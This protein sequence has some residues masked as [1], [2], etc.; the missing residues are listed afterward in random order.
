MTNHWNDL[1]YA[2]V[3][4]VIG[5]NPAENHPISF[6][7]ITKAKEKGAKLISVDPRY[8]RTSQM[9]DMYGQLRSGTDIAFIGGIINYTLENEL[10][11][12]EYVANYT[13]AAN[14]VAD[15]FS[16]DDGMFNGYDE[17]KRSYDKTKWSFKTDEAGKTMKDMTMKDPNCVLQLMKK[18]YSRY[19]IDTV[20]G[21][22]G[23]D[24]K[25]YLEICKTY[26][27]T[28]EIG[29]AGTI[30][31]AMGAT[32]HT[33]GTQ[34][35]RSY[36]ILQMLLGNIG[37]QG[38]GVNALRGESNVQGST[39]FGLLYDNVP[40]Y[41]GV[42]KAIEG[43]KTYEGFLGRITPK[44]G[45][46]VNFP[47]FYTSMLKSF[48]GDHATKEN[49]FGYQ[50]LP[51]ISGEKNYSFLR[52]FDAMYRKEL[53]GLLMFGT[54][55]VVGGANSS[56]S[57]ESLANLK[58]LVAI[59]LWETESSAF[60]QKEAGSDPASIQTEVIFLPACSSFEKEGS[61][62]NSGRWM[63]YRWQAIEPKGESKADLEIVH[64]LALKLKEL[65]KNSSNPADAPMQ[66]LTWDYG[67]G[68]HPDIDLVCREING[69]D[70]ATKQQVTGFGNLKDDGSTCC[71][72]WIY[73]GFYPGNENLAKRR[74]NKDT[75]NSNFLNW[76]FAWPANRRIL[77]NRA[78]ADLNGKAWSKDRVGVEWDPVQKKWVGNDVP[79]FVATK[80]PDDP[81]FNDPFI[82]QT[83]G[84]GAIFSSG[85]NEGPFPEHYE[86]YENPVNNSFSKVQLNPAVQFGEEKLS[87]KGDVK[88]Y[89]IVATTYRVSEHWQ[90]GAMTRNLPWLAE[91]VPHMYVE[92]S[93]ELAKEK[94][95][96]NGDKVIVSSVRD[97]IEVYAMVTKRFKPYK[98]KDKT[99]HHIGMPWHFGYKGIATGATANNLTPHIGDA[100]STIPE[101]KAFLCD[102]RR[103]K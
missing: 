61:V 96:K 93:E 64:L 48:Y 84:K 11:P 80:G 37:I 79:D 41:I 2:D 35:I 16:F 10:Y 83:D 52:L 54:N 81:T 58:W 3:L 62:T 31:Y 88:K 23:T 33:V 102:V 86:P 46:K 76:S 14:I 94:G 82:M 15:D 17:K 70:M 78:S 92:I 53:E 72:N 42:P 75:G 97:E 63:Q 4:M 67:H 99:V 95:I 74:D 98:L 22:T 25:A 56:K 8:T 90:A 85:L 18:H 39:D 57:K 49:E 91:L 51:K 73:S 101:Y 24:K 87:I 1:Q 26:A 71:G 89:P 60:W 68:D 21:V 55:P 27:S 40:G 19:D 38:G 30:L 20:C 13:N 44:S 100:N 7:W 36:A 32:Q 66:N 12:K 28:G 77:Y 43:D 65:Y 45:Y 50:W 6:R 9:A 69:Y 103:A 5:A 29:K 47:K 34:N 59:D